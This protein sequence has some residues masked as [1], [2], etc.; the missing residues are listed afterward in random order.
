MKTTCAHVEWR[1]T[2]SC[3]REPVKT[4]NCRQLI[5]GTANVLTHPDDTD[6]VSR[7]AARRAASAESRRSGKLARPARSWLCASSM[8]ATAAPTTSPVVANRATPPRVDDAAVRALA[9]A[10]HRE[11]RESLEPEDVV[12]IASELLG[13]VA[14]E[15][16]GRRLDRERNG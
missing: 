1:G 12:R 16:Q 13:R 15:L 3:R 5:V 7:F 11:L 9:G 2:Y 6:R 8:S 14:D 10:I 4:V